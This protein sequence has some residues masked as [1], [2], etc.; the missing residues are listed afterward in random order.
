MINLSNPGPHRAT[1]SEL[2]NRGFTVR[3][4][5]HGGLFY[6]RLCK[7][8]VVRGFTGDGL[9][10]VLERAIAQLAER[11]AADERFCERPLTGGHFQTR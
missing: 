3:C 2:E 6:L 4:A 8:G 11:G 1:V 10:E 7:G 9:C 5:T